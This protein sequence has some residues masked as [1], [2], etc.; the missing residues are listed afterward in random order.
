MLYQRTA[1]SKQPETLIQQELHSLALQGQV[2]SNM[3]LK[4]P[5][6]LGFLDLTE[7]YLEKDL[8]DATLRDLE[9]FRLEPGASVTFIARMTTATRAFATCDRC[10]PKEISASQP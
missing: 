4:A 2:S 8:E 6:V 1:L 9:S 5:Y 3:V 7:H 10:S